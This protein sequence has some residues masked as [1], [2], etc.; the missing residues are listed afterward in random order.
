MEGDDSP[1]LIPFQD[2]MSSDDDSSLLD[3]D[4]LV[5][6]IGNLEELTKTTEA[7]TNAPWRRMPTAHNKRDTPYKI[8]NERKHCANKHSDEEILDMFDV[9]LLKLA[10]RD[11]CVKKTVDCGE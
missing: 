9:Y 1:L 8:I 7:T 2:A 3:V 5:Q 11:V 4:V 10:Q 6:N